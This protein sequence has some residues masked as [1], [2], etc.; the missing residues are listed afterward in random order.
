MNTSAITMSVRKREIPD[1]SLLYPERIGAYYH[2]SYETLMTKT[3]L[4]LPEIYRLAVARSPRWVNALM[5]VRDSVVTVLGVRRVGQIGS[6][7]LAGAT[8][9]A[10]G[11]KLDIFTLYASSDDEIV[12]GEDDSHL[13]F[14]L[15]LLRLSQEGHD[16]LVLS[17][18]V[19]THNAIGKAY[20]CTILPF[21]KLIMRKY[22]EVA[23]H[24]ADSKCSPGGQGSNYQ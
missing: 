4:T 23:S 16:K 3:Q 1:Q 15:S 20:L 12:V 19:K 8:T 21:H 14:R 5:A 18:V 9:P 2:D 22:L 17:M 24:A 10:V 6:G 11:A 13:D 7:T